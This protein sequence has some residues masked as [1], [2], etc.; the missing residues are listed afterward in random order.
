MGNK[1]IKYESVKINKDTVAALRE[2][3]TKS[4][5]PISVFIERLV[6]KALNKK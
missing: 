6:K 3:K 2:H 4:G 5:V 1:I